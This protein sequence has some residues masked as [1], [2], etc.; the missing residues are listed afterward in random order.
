MGFLFFLLSSYIKIIVI[1]SFTKN[2]KIVMFSYVLDSK[3]IVWMDTKMR[4]AILFWNSIIFVRSKYIHLH[5]STL[6]IKKKHLDSRK[7]N[8]N[9]HHN[10]LFTSL[11]NKNKI[12]SIIAKLYCA[13]CCLICTTPVTFTSDRLFEVPFGFGRTCQATQTDTNFSDLEYDYNP[14]QWWSLLTYIN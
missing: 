11:K 14:K 6:K 8:L 4:I 5:L 12:E 9:N 2:N 1:L 7:I 3:I 10:L 13:P